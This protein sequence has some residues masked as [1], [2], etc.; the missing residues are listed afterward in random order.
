MTEA[1]TIE[2]QSIPLR[3]EG[4]CFCAECEARTQETYTVPMQCTNC[5]WEGEGIFR[6]GDKVG[7]RDCP[8]CG[9]YYATRQKITNR[10]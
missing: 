5:D 8:K 10:S 7:S 1:R 3:L 9:V 2:Q 4:R 6:K